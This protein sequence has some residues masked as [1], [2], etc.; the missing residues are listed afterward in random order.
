MRAVENDTLYNN[1]GPACYTT[2]EN[3]WY[4]LGL[5]NTNVIGV[6]LDV[7]APTI[8]CKPGNLSNLPIA[9]VEKKRVALTARENTILSKDDWNSFETSWDFKKHPMV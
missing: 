6:F 1:K 7:L 5:L 9:I 3:R 4:F 2:E 8:D